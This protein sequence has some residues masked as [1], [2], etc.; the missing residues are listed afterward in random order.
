MSVKFIWHVAGLH[1][2]HSR[3]QPPRVDQGLDLNPPVT[4]A[5]DGTQD[6]RSSN[7]R[8]RISAAAWWLNRETM[9]WLER[10][11]CQSP[12]CPIADLL[13]NSS[14]MP[15][16]GR[17]DLLQRKLSVSHRFEIALCSAGVDLETS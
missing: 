12:L 8:L 6:D 3:R 1:E 4:V 7:V 2:R 11:A 13:P 17:S 10:I 14:E 5:H 15:L 9:S 16:C